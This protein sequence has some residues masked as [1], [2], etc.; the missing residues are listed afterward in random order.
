MRRGSCICCR[1]RAETHAGEGYQTEAKWGGWA[2][3]PRKKARR[4]KAADVAAL[5]VE[6]S[7]NGAHDVCSGGEGEILQVLGVRRRN[8]SSRH[9]VH[10]RIQI[11][12]RLRCAAA[13]GREKRAEGKG[14]EE[15]R[16]K[17][18]RVKG[19]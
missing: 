16:K 9:A 4:E 14:R 15:K 18:V 3:R 8:I 19:R 12:K 11:I 17:K 7:L 6:H 1:S 13:E 2:H 10:R 5:E